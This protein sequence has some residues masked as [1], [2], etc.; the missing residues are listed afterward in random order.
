[1]LPPRLLWCDPRPIPRFNLQEPVTIVVR[2]PGFHEPADEDDCWNFWYFCQAHDSLFREEP[3][4]GG[5]HL[6]VSHCE[7]H[8]P[9][10]VWPQPLMLLFPEGF[11]PPLSAEQLA[12]VQAEND[13]V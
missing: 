9:E 1:M 12:W 6:V 5:P 10:N 4:R 2:D 11:D 3:C 13:A 8:G 7:E